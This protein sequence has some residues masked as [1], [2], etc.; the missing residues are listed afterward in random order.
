MK[1]KKVRTS[2]R[3]VTPDVT[4]PAPVLLSGMAGKSPGLAL[5][6]PQNQPRKKGNAETR[7]IQQHSICE[8][9]KGDRFS[10]IQP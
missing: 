2:C 7:F 10:N 5:R 8:G 1:Q 9:D 4:S 6:L 3:K